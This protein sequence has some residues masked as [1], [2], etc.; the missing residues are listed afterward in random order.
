MYSRKT[1]LAFGCWPSPISPDL[2]A[3]T[4]ALDD[5]CFWQDRLAWIERRSGRGQL[6]SAGLA[7]AAQSEPSVDLATEHDLRGGVC[8]GGGALASSGDSLFFVDRGERLF[9]QRGSSNEPRLIQ[10]SFGRYASPCLHPA[11]RWLATVHHYQGQDCLALLDVQGE[12]WPIRLVAGADFYMQPTWSSNGDHLAWVEWDFPHMPWQRTRLCLADFHADG[13]RVELGNRRV[14]YEKDAAAFQPTFAPAP[15]AKSGDVLVFASDQ[16]GE[17][18]LYCFDV[19][20][21]TVRQLTTLKRDL[22]QPAWL[23]GLRS[24]AFCASG[25]RLYSVCSDAGFQQLLVFDIEA[26]DPS[27]GSFFQTGEAREVSGLE[28]YSSL[29]AITAHPTKPGRLAMIASS[30]TLPARIVEWHEADPHSAEHRTSSPRP[31]KSYERRLSRPDLDPD[32]LSTPRAVSF[33]A[34]DDPEAS[35]HG[36]FY[37]PTSARYRGSGLPPAL[38]MV[39]GGPTYHWDTSFRLR[40]QFLTSRG[41]AVLELDYRGSSGYGRAY[42]RALDGK[43]G[44]LDVADAL[45]ARQ[46]LIDQK[47]ADPRRIG[48]MGGSAGG[49]TVLCA[50]VN[51]PGVFAVGVSLYG[52]GNLLSLARQTHKFEARYLDSLIGP[53]PQA[54]E[55]YRERSAV[56]AADRIRDPLAIFQGAEDQAVP[57][58]QAEE[59]VAALAKQKLPH[60]YRLY[61]NEGHG[62][63]LP[64]TLRAHFRDLEQFLTSYLVYR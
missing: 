23:Q 21:E 13:D 36:L 4:A 59:F 11:S 31:N 46:Y 18:E 30:P 58:D 41:F 38:V 60:L 56:F 45:A 34:T 47:L 9:V 3:T 61:A 5:V 17:N 50:L 37:A 64:E 40:T 2:L 63:R 24:F 19:R 43:W 35:A 39:H 54:A 8:S 49:F 42:Q 10:P 15:L 52:I 57:P 27:R 55:T 33:A 12:H 32:T 44:V 26:Q 48:I 25:K 16:S 1:E 7:D 6:V 22:A 62:F 29:R 14:I 53:L 20:T 51:H 28:R